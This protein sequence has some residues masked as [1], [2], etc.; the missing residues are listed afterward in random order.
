MS[1]LSKG[2]SASVELL[3]WA[4]ASQL[5]PQFPQAPFQPNVVYQNLNQYSLTVSQ[6]QGYY[7]QM[8]GETSSSQ[9]Q[10]PEI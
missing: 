2:L 8:F 1:D 6:Q 7:A 9:S 10:N 3:S 5:Q 4:I